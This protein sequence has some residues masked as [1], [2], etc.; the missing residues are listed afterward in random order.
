MSDG[1]NVGLTS[2]F[3]I[4]QSTPTSPNVLSHQFLLYA[5][6]YWFRHFE[7]SPRSA[8]DGPTEEEKRAVRN[9]LHS[10]NF[11]TDADLLRQYQTFQGEWCQLLQAQPSDSFRGEV[12]RCFWK[13]LG[14]AN[15]LS[16]NESRYVAFEV[17]S[18]ASSR[19]GPEEK[20]SCQFHHVSKDGRLLSTAWI[21]TRENKKE[22]CM[23]QWTLDGENHPQLRFSAITPFSATATSI[24]R[25]TL[26]C[27]ESVSSIPLIPSINSLGSKLFHKRSTE[28][29]IQQASFHELKGKF[30]TDSWEEVCIR[31]P[32]MA[33][34]RRR[35]YREQP[36][37]TDKER[38]SRRVKRLRRRML[39]RARS[40]S[41]S[42]SASP[43]PPSFDGSLGAFLGSRMPKRT[44]LESGF[45]N[46][47]GSGS[48]NDAEGYSGDS[49]TSDSLTQ[50]NISSG[51]ESW[52]EAMSDESNVSSDAS[53]LSQ[54][55]TDSNDDEIHDNLDAEYTT[56]DDV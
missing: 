50:D 25:Y 20:G 22:L 12:D 52:S 39:R 16:S 32:F 23:E 24:A 8:K 48:D 3:R 45:S 49:E 27:A 53:I 28:N 6:K 44:F 30:L 33:V 31:E 40:G 4:R 14:P 13:A 17:G 46:F 35:V 41:R 10:P 37:S 9:F 1:R 47:V 56:S 34:S 21:Q 15:F 43:L 26:P 11:L 54:V 18:G 7:N 51:E 55:P 36:C 29:T 2:E 5:V 42:R 38:E 19:L